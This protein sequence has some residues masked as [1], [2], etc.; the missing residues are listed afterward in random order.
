MHKIDIHIIVSSTNSPLHR[1]SKLLSISISRSCPKTEHHMKESWNSNHDLQNIIIPP[2]HEKISFDVVQLFPSMRL[3]LIVIGIGKRWHLIEN[4]TL[5]S[6]DEFLEAVNLI[7]KNTHSQFDGEFYKQE[8][9][10]PRGLP[11]SPIVAN[12]VMEDCIENCLRVL[13]N[14]SN[15]EP[16]ILRIFADD[17]LAVIP[18]DQ[19]RNFIRTFNENNENLDFTIEKG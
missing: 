19:V 1:L 10:A 17:G 7:F 9:G 18:R 14:T 2:H 11:L 16:I 4:H 8:D 3:R 12:L 15:F 13:E 5:L 6:K